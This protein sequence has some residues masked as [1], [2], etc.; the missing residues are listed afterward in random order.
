M[1]AQRADQQKWRGACWASSAWVQ[2]CVGRNHGEGGSDASLQVLS[3]EC[4]TWVPGGTCAQGWGSAGVLGTCGHQGSSAGSGG[5]VGPWVYLSGQCPTRPPRRPWPAVRA[6]PEGQLLPHCFE[7]ACL[8]LQHSCCFSSNLVSGWVSPGQSSAAGLGAPGT[9]CEWGWVS[10]PPETPCSAASFHAKAT[11]K[12]QGEG[13]GDLSDLGRAC[14]G[15]GVRPGAQ[16]PSEPHGDPPSHWAQRLSGLPSVP[17]PTSALK[18][19]APGSPCTWRS[20]SLLLSFPSCL[21]CPSTSTLLG[22][23]WGVVKA[24][25]ALQGLHALH[26]FLTNP[27][28]LPVPS[29]AIGGGKPQERHLRFQGLAWSR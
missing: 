6:W 2:G 12:S 18:G 3:A 11:G 24:G 22:G 29:G 4:L 8:P 19:G 5:V 1:Y 14:T 21:T 7:A 23:G 26:N 20:W 17:L 13:G 25:Q 15:G 9:P 28:R 27:C 16:R 10:P